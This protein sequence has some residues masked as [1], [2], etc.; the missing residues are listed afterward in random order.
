MVNRRLMQERARRRLQW[1][2]GVC[3]VISTV[4]FIVVGY[5]AL[6]GFSDWAASQTNTVTQ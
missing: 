2:S 6:G 3:A 4:L 5:A 1:I